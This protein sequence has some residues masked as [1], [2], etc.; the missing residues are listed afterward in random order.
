MECKSVGCGLFILRLW[1]GKRTRVKFWKCSNRF[2]SSWYDCQ[3]SAMSMWYPT[4][5]Y[6]FLFHNSVNYLSIISIYSEKRVSGG[7]IFLS[8]LTT[9][10]SHWCSSQYSQFIRVSLKNILHLFNPDKE[11]NKEIDELDPKIDNYLY[12]TDSVNFLFK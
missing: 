5:N 7:D 11:T 3:F 12:F 1:C 10:S 8:C 9:V 6:L 4:I 2:F